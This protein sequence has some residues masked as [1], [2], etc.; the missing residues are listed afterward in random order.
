MKVD[1]VHERGRALGSTHL[2]RA[3]LAVFAVA[4]MTVGTLGVTAQDAEAV[5]WSPNVKIAGNVRCTEGVTGRASVTIRLANGET[6]SQRVNS[7]GNYGLWFT[8]VPFW[9]T[10]AKVTVTCPRWVGGT[11]SKTWSITVVRPAF[12]YQQNIQRLTV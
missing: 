12:G 7:L 9:G 5:T 3:L 4:A 10:T 2:R 1:Q 8:S 11:R 6:N